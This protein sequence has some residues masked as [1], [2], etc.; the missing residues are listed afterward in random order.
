MSDST[1]GL[2]GPP[3]PWPED[4]DNIAAFRPDSLRYADVPIVRLANGEL[5]VVRGDLSVQFTDAAQVLDALQVKGADV[6]QEFGVFGNAV[7]D[8]LL[9]E[10]GER[11]PS[12]GDPRYELYVELDRTV[13]TVDALIGD[14]AAAISR[15][16][17]AAAAGWTLFGADENYYG[18]TRRDYP[19]SR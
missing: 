17:R 2:T 10:P 13:A 15:A 14:L 1:F 4:A 6:E 19:R 3:N 7:G 12:N 5:V 18:L 8:L 9:L 16:A 11:L